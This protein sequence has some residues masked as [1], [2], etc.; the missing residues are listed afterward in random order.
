MTRCLALIL[1]LL[2]SGCFG[3]SSSP[4]RTSAG[5]AVDWT[6]GYPVSHWIR[7]G[8]RLSYELLVIRTRHVGC[9]LDAA[10]VSEDCRA[11]EVLRHRRPRCPCPI[12]IDPPGFVRGFVDGRV[13]ELSLD[14]CCARPA[15]RAALQTL[16]PTA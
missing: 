10:P 7:G 14:T 5:A 2:A 13:V 11:I 4:Q 1:L 12:T 9:P 3:E 8:S 6:I 16:H 15:V